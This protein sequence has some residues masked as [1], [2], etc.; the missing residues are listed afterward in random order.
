M[1]Y[2]T[3]GNHWQLFAT[4]NFKTQLYTTRKGPVVVVVVA[5]VADRPANQAD[6]QAGSKKP[7]GGGG[8]K[9]A[10]RSTT[11]TRGAD[12]STTYTGG[13]DRSTTYTGADD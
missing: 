8:D 6:Y 9:V 4:S 3:I 12:R 13:A 10:D 5:M 1:N 11:Y 2:N 7:P